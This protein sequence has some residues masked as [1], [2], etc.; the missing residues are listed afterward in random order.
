MHKLLSSKKYHAQPKDGKN[1]HAQENCTNPSLQ[2][3]WSI[4][5][6]DCSGGSRWRCWI[7][8][9]ETVGD[10]PLVQGYTSG[11]FVSFKVFKV[12]VKVFV[13]DRFSGIFERPRNSIESSQGLSGHRSNFGQFLLSVFSLWGRE[14][15]QIR[16]VAWS[17]R[18][19]THRKGGGGGGLRASRGG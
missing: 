3:Q 7:L 2:N 19:G 10:A 18:L 15:T 1:F 13:F 6:R 16:G 14:Q 11:I 8:P 4:P 9:H 12:F 17:F 5:T